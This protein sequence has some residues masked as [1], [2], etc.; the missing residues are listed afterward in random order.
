MNTLELH[1]STLRNRIERLYQAVF[2]EAFAGNDDAYSEEGLE[3]QRQMLFLCLA[4]K[5][6]ELTQV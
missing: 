4:E 2:P 5:L 1:F 6:P 3:K